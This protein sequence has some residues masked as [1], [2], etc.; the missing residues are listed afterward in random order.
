MCQGDVQE[1]GDE[2]QKTQ[3]LIPQR[4]RNHRMNGAEIVMAFIPA[5]APVDGA[6]S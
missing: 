3:S 6:I 5:C 1:A 4:R 2:S